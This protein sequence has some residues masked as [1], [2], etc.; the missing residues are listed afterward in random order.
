MPSNNKSALSHL[1]RGWPQAPAEPQVSVSTDRR[2][3][4]TPR[5]AAIE[6]DT[7]SGTPNFNIPR[8]TGNVTAAQIAIA[9]RQAMIQN[10]RCP[11]AKS[12]EIVRPLAPLTRTKVRLPAVKAMNANARATSSLP[13]RASENQ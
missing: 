2:T 5:A 13:L 6:T 11:L 7:I 9:P 10:E 3:E 8:K 1:K 12:L 4:L